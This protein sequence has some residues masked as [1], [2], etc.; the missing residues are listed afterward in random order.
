MPLPARSR[1]EPFGS[2]GPGSIDLNQR[3]GV[4]AGVYCKLTLSGGVSCGRRQEFSVRRCSRRQLSPARRMHAMAT[5]LAARV[6]AVQDLAAR[7]SVARMSRVRVSAA[8]IWAVPVSAAHTW[9]VRALQVHASARHTWVR[10]LPA[11]ELPV[12]VPLAAPGK[13]ENDKAATGRAAIGAAA[14]GTDA[15]GR[16]MRRW[17]SGSAWA[18]I[19]AAT[20][21]TTTRMST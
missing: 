1:T 15:T 20:M 14:A 19:T 9:V 13:A 4:A 7:E 5:A 8:H 17:V 3:A 2:K 18:G 12:Q 6:W 10:V 16:I 11:R 21:T